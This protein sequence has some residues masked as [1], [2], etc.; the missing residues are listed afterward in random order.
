MSHFGCW[1]AENWSCCG[2]AAV[3]F[4]REWLLWWQWRRVSWSCVGDLFNYYCW[5]NSCTCS[6]HKLFYRRNYELTSYSLQ[7]YSCGVK[8]G[9]D[10]ES[11][12][13]GVLPRDICP[14]GTPQTCTWRMSP[15]ILGTHRIVHSAPPKRWQYEGMDHI[16]RCLQHWEWGNLVV[17][18]GWK[19]HSL[20][21]H[22]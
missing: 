20:G 15:T 17:W 5:R 12:D 19:P 21:E 18:T 2:G 11:Y 10:F 9:S 6:M 8:K 14:R 7:S 4:V 1:S 13:L 3:S 16:L 22:V